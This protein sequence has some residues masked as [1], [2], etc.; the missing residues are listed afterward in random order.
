MLSFSGSLKIYLA[1]EPRDLRKGFDGLAADVNGKLGAQ[2][3]SG[4]L[5]VFCNR[6]RTRLKVLYWDGSGIWILTKRLEEGHF[7]WPAADAADG[8]TPWS[9]HR[10]Y[11]NDSRL[12]WKLGRF[13]ALRRNFRTRFLVLRNRPSPFPVV[14]GRAPGN[15]ARAAT[16]LESEA[17]AMKSIRLLLAALVLAPGLSAEHRIDARTP[18]GLRDLFRPER[19]PLPFVSAHRG[20][21]Q[22]GFPENCL[23]SFEHTLRHTFAIMEI[24]PRYAKDGAIVVHHDAT[25]ERTTTGRGKVSDFTLAELKQLRLKDPEGNVTHEVADIIDLEPDYRSF[26]RR[27][28]DLVETDI[29]VRLGPLLRGP[30]PVSPTKAP[31]LI[32]FPP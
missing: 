19:G 15:A 1:V 22:E 12:G 28:A 20:G 9:D 5:F 4:A 17:A 32:P 6:R 3:K 29:P 14:P 2:V 13:W 26:L 18:N 7:S 25:L 23:E 11:C 21:A 27:G 31:Y 24:D 8:G 10:I 30:A 16:G